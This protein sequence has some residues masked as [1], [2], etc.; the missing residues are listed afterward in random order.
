MKKDKFSW[1]ELVTGFNEK[2]IESFNKNHNEIYEIDDLYRV[3]EETE[4]EKLTNKDRLKEL[5]TLKAPIDY[6]DSN[7]SANALICMDYDDFNTKKY[8]HLE[9]DKSLIFGVLTNLIPFPET[10]Q[11]PRNMFSCG[12]TK[13]ATSIYSSN[14][15]NRMDKSGIV[16]N[17]GQ[18]PLVKTRYLQYLNNEEM[19][20]GGELNSSNYVLW[21]L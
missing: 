13:Q 3:K 14:Y 21:W 9:I 17:S 19:P 8:T 20:Y 6:I 11:A 2:K 15:V 16:L 18:V 10:N 5:Q 4:K 1:E 12:Q 7:E